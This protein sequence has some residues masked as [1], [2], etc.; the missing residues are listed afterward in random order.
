[1]TVNYASRDGTA[2]AGKDYSPTRGPL[3]I[4]AAD[5]E[6]W[7]VVKVLADTTFEADEDFF[8]DLSNT[9]TATIDVGTADG[10]FQNDDSAPGI[11]IGDARASEGDGHG[12][13][14][15]MLVPVA[16]SAAAGLPVSV[17]Y[18]A[19]GYCA[20]GGP[21]VGFN[22]KCDEP[23]GTVEFPADDGSMQFI[24]IPIWG[25]LTHQ[26]DRQFTITLS[27]PVNGRIGRA[28]ATATVVDNDP[29]PAFAVED[30]QVTERDSGKTRVNLRVTLSNPTVE[31]A[32]FRAETVQG[33]ANPNADYGAVSDYAGVI[34]AGATSATV[35]VDVNGDTE[36]EPDEYFYLNVFSLSAAATGATYGTVTIIDDD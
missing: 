28:N 35:A 36:V 30:S 31:D 22:G 25:N 15:R 27:N 21:I 5:T 18:V 3:T 13:A 14:T 34:P 6:A 10:I 7:I 23:R 24:T 20:A 8:V 11:A 32:P 1:V 2:I 33:L 4:K 19:T 17:H 29:V 26:P 16:V 9:I 12:L